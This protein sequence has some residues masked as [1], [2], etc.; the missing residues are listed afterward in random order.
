MIEEILKNKIKYECN[1]NY[2]DYIERVATKFAYIIIKNKKVVID[3]SLDPKW[4][5]SGRTREINE[6]Y[7]LQDYE[8]FGDFLEN[9][10]NGTSIASYTSGMG[11]YHETYSEDFEKLSYE[12]IF[13]QLYEVIKQLIKNNNKILKKWIKKRN[14]ENS[15]KLLDEIYDIIIYEDL[16]GDFLITNS[17][18]LLISIKSINPM[19]LFNRGKTI[20]LK[21]I[22]LENIKSKRKREKRKIERKEA[23]KIWNKISKMYKLK[24]NKS[25]PEKI[26]KSHYNNRIKSLLKQINNNGIHISKIQNIGEYLGY[27]FSNSV[28]RII[29][30]F[31]K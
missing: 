17:I 1:N 15:K 25:I 8:T 12:W 7:N 23:E 16:I 26:N 28:E 31:K 11:L 27:N 4:D 19:I 24:Y 5:H 2:G 18:E 3:H 21:K 10:Y 30:N 29:I 13:D 22:R 20:A 9:E 6:S 14:I